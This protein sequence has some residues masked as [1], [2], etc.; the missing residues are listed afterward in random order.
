MFF[1][2]LQ[3]SFGNY[4][5]IYC[6]IKCL[7][8]TSSLAKGGNIYFETCKAGITLASFRILHLEISYLMAQKC[9]RKICNL[10]INRDDIH[11]SKIF[12]YA[13]VRKCSIILIT[14]FSHRFAVE[15][16]LTS[17]WNHQVKRELVHFNILNKYGSIFK[18][19]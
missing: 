5:S 8:D 17:L 10:R 14:F 4:S 2:K 16:V 3:Y 11:Y 19:L 15:N 1:W 18:D 7:L 13:N 12:R 6:N 9:N